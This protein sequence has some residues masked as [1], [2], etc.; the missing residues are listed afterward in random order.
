MKASFGNRSGDLPHMG[1][2]EQLI[3]FI[4]HCHLLSLRLETCFTNDTKYILFFI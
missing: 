2:S 4:N 1:R 3:E